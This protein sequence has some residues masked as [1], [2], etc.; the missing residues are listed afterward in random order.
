VSKLTRTPR[1][2][3][4]HSADDWTSTPEVDGYVWNLGPEPTGPTEAEARW[5][6]ET[7][8]DDHHTD[9]PTPDH[10]LELQYEVSMAQDQ[11]ERGLPM[12]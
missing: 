4:T 6:A 5:A 11:M 9:E 7:L 8:N 12:F 3:Q 1:P 2:V 10:V